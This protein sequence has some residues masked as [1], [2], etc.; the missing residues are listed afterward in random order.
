MISVRDNG[1]GFDSQYA[2]KLFGVFQ[3]LHNPRDFEGIGVGLA[4]I[5]RIVLK[6]GGGRTGGVD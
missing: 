1:I 4:T 2:K 5:R 6:H 3:R